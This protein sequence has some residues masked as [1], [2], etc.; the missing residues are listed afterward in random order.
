MQITESIE[1]LAPRRRVFSLLLDE[2]K[3]MRLNPVL[4][5]V[6][7]RQLTEG[8][9]GEGTRFLV[10]I[11][12][13]KQRME[14]VEEWLEV[15]VNRKIV[16][17]TLEGPRFTVTQTLSRTPRGSKLTYVED[18]PLTHESELRL[19]RRYLRAWLRSIKGYLELDL[20]P[21][22]RLWKGFLDRFL[23]KLQPRERRIAQLIL[24]IEGA[25]LLAGLLALATFIIVKSLI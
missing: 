17:K 16:Y 3:R 12:M 9:P 6:E 23:L 20:H 21:H 14:Y 13:A 11:K 10:R 24:L 22:T 25:T 15:K 2:E 7:V 1:I 18:T 8:A 5:E 19:A 4:D